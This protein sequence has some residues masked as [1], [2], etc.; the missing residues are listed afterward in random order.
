MPA[1][2][3]DW[4]CLALEPTHDAQAIKRAYAAKLRVTRPDDDALA[5][6]ALRE[7]YD[8][9]LRWA[10]ESC[11][12]I[13]TTEEHEQDDTPGAPPQPSLPAPPGDD[14]P[15]PTR[16]ARLPSAPAAP[17]VHPR[18]LV[19]RLD[20]AWQPAGEA[21]WPTAW[22]EARIGLQALPLAAADESSR[23]FADWIIATPG[24]PE[25]AL[26]QLCDEFGWFED[27]R[28]GQQLGATRLEALR[29]RVGEVASARPTDPEL[30]ARCEPVTRL[31]RLLQGQRRLAAWCFSLLFG[32]M[33]FALVRALGPQGLRRIGVPAQV[34]QRLHALAW[35]TVLL[36][37][38][39][40]CAMLMA[41]LLALRTP[42]H[43]AWS[44]LIGTLGV[45]AVFW[46][47]PAW[48]ARIFS[49]RKPTAPTGRMA[50]FRQRARGG[51]TGLVLLLAALLIGL[52]VDK[53]AAS[54]EVFFAFALVHFACWAAGLWLAWP[55]TTNSRWILYGGALLALF[56]LA[57]WLRD[58]P[59][60][61]LFTV[62]A[63]W[64]LLGA[65][66]H[67]HGIAGRVKGGRLEALTG[68]TLL[69]CAPFVVMQVVAQRHG[70]RL[71]LAPGLLVVAA[72]NATTEPA[73]V[74]T[75]LAWC[76]MTFAVL[77][78]QNRAERLA[79]RCFKT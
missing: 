14:A 48:I 7:A 34:Q 51:A 21:A 64:S 4:S 40:W 43:L 66:L 13:D 10:R 41:T 15:A 72:A 71:A 12:R 62:S 36:R 52:F 46:A 61:T 23:V 42:A 69:L 65:W 59:G 5:Y 49:R 38:A 79:L 19:Q 31:A 33:L 2:R 37:G 53:D 63:L 32:S 18:G 9:A 75:V 47:G 8:R 35:P 55:K 30:L 67:D 73:P 45:A 27:F 44:S 54:P 58:A 29:E 50:A 57:P 11:R 56:A 3:A 70:W 77:L 26:R 20:A 68:W 78:G 16:Q 24:L 28:A 76:L 6:Q 25:A 39:V 17:M 22:R 60:F 1:S 74:W